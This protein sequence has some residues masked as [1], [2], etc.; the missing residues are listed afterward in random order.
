MFVN[1]KLKKSNIFAAF[2][3]GRAAKGAAAGCQTGRGCG[4]IPANTFMGPP[5]PRLDFDVAGP[6]HPAD[7]G[8]IRPSPGGGEKHVSFRNLMG[9]PAPHPGLLFVRTK[10][11]QKTARREKPFR[12]GFSPVTPSSATT[13][14]GAPAPLWN[15]PH[16]KRPVLNSYGYSRQCVT[17]RMFRQVP[18]ETCIPLRGRQAEYRR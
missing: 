9:L 18:I 11:N 2:P 1:T 17:R 14:R 13:Q 4:T 6:A 16:K 3:H 15:P 5:A 7:A 12:W 10:S 8:L